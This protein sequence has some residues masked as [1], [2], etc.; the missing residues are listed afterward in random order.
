[1]VMSWELIELILSS[2]LQSGNIKIIK[3][4]TKLYCCLLFYMGGENLI[5]HIGERTKRVSEIR[6]LGNSWP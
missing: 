1:M 6:G 5:C 4:Y 2:C 3:W